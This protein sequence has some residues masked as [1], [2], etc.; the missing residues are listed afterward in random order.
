MSRVASQ[1]EVGTAH[2]QAAATH[3]RTHGL[4]IVA[5]NFACRFGEI[6]LV[7]RDGDT[8]VFVE[9]RYR[10]HAEFG[11]AVGS[12]D[13]HKQRRIVRAARW[14]LAQNPAAARSP[15]RFD[16]VAVTGAPPHG[17]AWLRDAFTADR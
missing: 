8:T 14:Y 16:V 2:E 3:L 9:V 13:E 10:S 5:R 4:T 1:R 7:C 15:C 17:V 11:G 6:D 12:V